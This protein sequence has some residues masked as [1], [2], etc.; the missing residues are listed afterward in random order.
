[1]TKM[2]YVNA[3]D[4]V[5]ATVDNDEVRE[6][7]EALKGQLM[8][9]SSGE[10][11]PTKTQTENESLKEDISAYVSENGAKRASEVAV[12]FGMSGQK[13]SALLKQLVDAQALERFIEKRVTYFR[14]AE[15]E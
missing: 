4:Y 1:M 13:A 15:G 12:Y 14:V 8:K 6:K 2:T 11:K 9:R 5:L 3:L 10:R 7:L